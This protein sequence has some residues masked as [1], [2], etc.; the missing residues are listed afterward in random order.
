MIEFDYILRGYEVDEY[1]YIIIDKYGE[2]SDVVRCLDKSYEYL[3]ASSPIYMEQLNAIRKFLYDNQ[4]KM[5]GLPS[6]ACTMPTRCRIPPERA[7]IFSWV[8]PDKLTDCNSWVISSSS[9][10]R[11]MPLRAPMY[12]KNSSTEKSR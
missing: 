7:P 11:G 2:D 4:Y 10:W 8:A 1:C 12:R 5:D 9:C 3:I 6:T